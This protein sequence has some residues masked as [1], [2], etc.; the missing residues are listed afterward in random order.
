MK[1]ALELASDR[2]APGDHVKGS[3][4][5]AEGGK[6]RALTLTLSFHEQTR[7]YS[8]VPFSADAVLHQGDLMAGQSFDFSFELPAEAAPSTKA[9]HSELYWELVVTSDERGLDTHA[10]RRLEVQSSSRT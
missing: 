3:V 10:S 5:V 6:S 7:D 4:N 1:L 8:A 9:E 2:F